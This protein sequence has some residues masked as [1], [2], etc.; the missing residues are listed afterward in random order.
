MSASEVV[1]SERTYHRAYLCLCETCNALTLVQVNVREKYVRLSSI[2]QFIP[3][4]LPFV[5]RVPVYRLLDRRFRDRK[6]WA[7][8]NK[9]LFRSLL[10]FGIRQLI[11]I[12][13]YV[14]SD[15]LDFYAP[16]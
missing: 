12:M 5:S 2:S 13:A 10:R 14:S 4:H 1:S 6:E 16:L 8:T 7:W 11:S 15:P 9:V 3:A